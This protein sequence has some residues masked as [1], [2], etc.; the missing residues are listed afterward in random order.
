MPARV[1]DQLG[2]QVPGRSGLAD[3]LERRR[4]G[5]PLG[6]RGDRRRA[7]RRR[8][9]RPGLERVAPGL[10]PALDAAGADEAAHQRLE[11]VALEV[12]ELLVEVALAAGRG[13]LGG[14]APA[15]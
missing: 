10:G 8:P 15:P 2:Q 14:L 3:A 13:L 5:P 7:Q 11:A 9:G 6:L 4:P 1:L 12:R